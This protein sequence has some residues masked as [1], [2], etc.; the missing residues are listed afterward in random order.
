MP[1]QRTAASPADVIRIAVTV[2]LG[3]IGAAAGFSHTHDWA[4]ANGQ[5]GWLAWADAVV[6]EGIAV[7][8]GFELRRDHHRAAQAPRQRRVSFPAVVLVAGVGVQM[9]AQ[10]A[11][12]PPTP[13]GW[14]LAATPA[15]G[16][17]VV[18]KLLMRHTPTE[19]TA[20][21]AAAPQAAEA[22]PVGEPGEAHPTSSA[23]R[24]APAAVSPGATVGKL[25]APLRTRL[26][27]LAEQAR[28]EGREL[29]TDDIAGTARLPEATATAVLAELNTPA[30]PA[31]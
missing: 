21:T 17:L 4:V 12:A 23:P 2:V 18:V 1:A 28:A 19:T 27:G 13:A 15:L 31:A 7:V 30:E 10:V 24:T 22:G 5:A 6:I 3:A 25:P 14:L 9:A 20:P 11:L 29:T 16:F 8:A 26:T